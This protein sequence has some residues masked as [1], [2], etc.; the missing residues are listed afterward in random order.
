MKGIKVIDVR[1][2]AAD[3]GFLVDDGETS[4]LFDSGFGFTGRAM[5][6]K[7]RA[8]LGT[9]PLDYIFLS[10]SHYDHALGAAYVLEDYPEARVVASEYAAKIFDK[11]T[12][13]ELMRKLDTALAVREGIGEYEDRTSALKVDIKVCDGDTVR[14]GDMEFRVIALPGH[15]KCSVGY[16]LESER[17]LLAP[18]T[19]GLY[20]DERVILPSP[21]VG[22]AMSLDSIER[23]RSLDIEN[24]VIPH[25]GL[26]DREE[27]AYY[28]DNAASALTEAVEEI[29]DT[30]AGGGTHD[31]AIE[32]FRKKYYTGSVLRSYPPDAFKLNTGITVALVER[33]LLSGDKKSI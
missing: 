28:L 21:L 3:S 26:L 19:L 16:Y 25:V 24:I 7:I 18:E 2:H 11:P 1:V 12:A 13:R 23:A 8:A 15:T 5:A 14:A 9:R 4:I 10:H 30:L 20:S 29:R 22:Y 27:T 32:K 6:E 33:E 17:L 31:E